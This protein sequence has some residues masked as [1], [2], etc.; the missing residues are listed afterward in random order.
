MKKKK[1]KKEVTN[2]LL[3]S[4][5]LLDDLLEIEEPSPVEINSSKA[6]NKEEGQ[7]TSPGIDGSKLKAEDRN[8]DTQ[9]STY[10]KVPI[11]NDMFIFNFCIR[12]LHEQSKYRETWRG[13]SV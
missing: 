1:Q 12:L 3:I 8:K 11:I 6:E 9:P 10:V 5:T 13:K 4:I 7:G 2:D